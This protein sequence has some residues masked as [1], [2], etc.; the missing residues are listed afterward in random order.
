MLARQKKSRALVA[1]GRQDEAAAAIASARAALLA[2][3][4]KLSD[5]TW[6]GRFLRDVPENARTLD[7][8]RQW[9]GG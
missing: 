7:L 3:A 1:G 9:L 2:R 4:D 8:A 5:P 6:R